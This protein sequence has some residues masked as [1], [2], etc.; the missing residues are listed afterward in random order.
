MAPIIA[1]P[2]L[3]D[4]YENFKF[5]VKW[6]GKYVA[7]VSMI[8][9][10]NRST[11]VVQNAQGGDSNISAK[12]PGPSQYYAITL[13]RGLSQDTAFEDWANL[14]Y[15]YGAAAGSES[16]A[17]FRKDIVIELYNEAGQ[18]VRAYDV[19][20]CWPS[21]FSALPNLNAATPGLAIETIT[22]E[23]EGW[24]RDASVVPPVQS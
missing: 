12:A 18:V 5:R 8:T 2:T 13:E 1:T 6:D 22:L 16:S 11:T 4:P 3:A 7:G 19:Y 20:R 17:A 23:N 9:G 14:V 10:L 24:Q 21:H 15:K